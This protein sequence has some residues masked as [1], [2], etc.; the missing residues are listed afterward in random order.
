MF[1]MGVN[2][3]NYDPSMKV[4][5]NASCT[6]NCLAPLAKVIHDEYGIV[7][8]VVTANGSAE[9]RVACNV[10]LTL[11]PDDNRSCDNCNSEDRGWPQQQEL[12]RRP[13]R[14]PEHHSGVHRGCQGCRQGEEEVGQLGLLR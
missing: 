3:E 8:G 5:S 4:V 12:A 6:T 2:H 13:R 1:V 10:Y 11:R 7:E 9:W 14:C